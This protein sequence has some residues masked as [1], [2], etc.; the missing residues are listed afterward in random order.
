MPCFCGPSHNYAMFA[1]TFTSAHINKLSIV[2][3]IDYNTKSEKTYN[4]SPTACIKTFEN[5]AQ[6]DGVFVQIIKLYYIYLAFIS[7]GHCKVAINPFV[8]KIAACKQIFLH[9][10]SYRKMDTWLICC[11]YCTHKPDIIYN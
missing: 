10:T 5:V 9:N 6:T 2:L 7:F 11:T 1:T 4:N 3:S 8:V